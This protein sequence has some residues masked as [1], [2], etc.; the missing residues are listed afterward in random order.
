MRTCARRRDG[1]HGH[2][3]FFRK[4][5]GTYFYVDDMA[6]AHPPAPSAIETDRRMWAYFDAGKREIRLIV[7]TFH[8]DGDELNAA[9]F[10]HAVRNILSGRARVDQAGWPPTR[11]G[12]H[13]GD[14]PGGWP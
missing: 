14:D 9:R 1:F 13:Q 8:E 6:S 2:Q 11:E 12:A 10:H 5:E 4:E 3:N 7:G